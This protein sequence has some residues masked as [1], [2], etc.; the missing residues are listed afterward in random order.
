MTIGTESRPLR[1]AI[2]GAGPSGFYAADALFK[3]GVPVEVDCF[4]RLPTPF[5]LLRA[6]VAPDH[7]KMKSVATYYDRVA[8]SN[9]NRFA[10]FGNVQVGTDISIDELKLFYD[11]IIV[12]SGAQHDRELGV[13]GELLP[14]VV[15]AASFVGWYNGHPDYTVP[16]VDLTVNAVAVIGQGNVAIDIARLLASPMDRLR[17]TD[18]PEPVLSVM[19]GRQIRTLHLIGRRGPVQSAFTELEIKELT[20]LAGWK[21]V[22]DPA[23]LTLAPQDEDELAHPSNSKAR[24]NIAVLREIAMKQTPVEP[25]DRVIYLRYLESPVQILGDQ[26]VSGV[27]LEQ[28][29]LAGDPGRRVAIGTGKRVTVDAQI[30]VKSIGYYGTA[31]PGVPFDQQSGTIP[32][33]AGGV[34]GDSALFVAGWIK[35]GPKGVLGTNKPCSTETVKTLLAAVPTLTPCLT[36]SS[37][38][39]RALLSARGVRWVSYADWKTLDEVERGRGAVLGKP[40]EKLTTIA[41]VFEALES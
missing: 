16:P 19:A 13:P 37:D 22:I 21:V 18:I 7:Q 23:V 20:E 12:A 36:P 33:Q 41:S 28:N 34:V 6:G 1:V 26:V 25:N 9:A 8:T 4:D 5:G 27:Q 39:V 38:K 29:Q 2:V 3:S 24:K 10:F 14:G 17:Q 11:A 35:R 32:N 40:R 15:G 31:I 30:V